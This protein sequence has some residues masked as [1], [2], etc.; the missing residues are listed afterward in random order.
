MAE[1]Y[2]P[3]DD[4]P[5]TAPLPQGKA[6]PAPRSSGSSDARPTI[7]KKVGAAK[8]KIKRGARGKPPSPSRKVTR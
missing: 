5:G 4:P 1:G 3:I 6:L 8:R 2:L 7:G